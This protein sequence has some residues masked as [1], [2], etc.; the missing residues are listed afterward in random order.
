MISLDHRQALKDI[1]TL[2]VVVS[3]MGCSWLI[4][5]NAS[6]LSQ[7]ADKLKF[8]EGT[9]FT[10]ADGDKLRD[11][12]VKNRKAVMENREKGDVTL[13]RLERLETQSGEKK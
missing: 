4:V 10:K 6:S 13:R 2:L 3:M 5:V 1:G 7:S 12:I 9:R 11:E 8:I